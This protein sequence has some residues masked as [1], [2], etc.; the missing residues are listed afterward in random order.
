MGILNVG[1]VRAMDHVE[2]SLLKLFHKIIVAE[3]A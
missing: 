1:I 2:L 3:S